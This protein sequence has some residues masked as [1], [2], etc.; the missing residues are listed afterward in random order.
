MTISRE[1]RLADQ[2]KVLRVMAAEV[3]DHALNTI[4]WDVTEPVFTGIV[5]TTWAELKERA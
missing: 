4:S 1:R 5:N 2:D 3:G